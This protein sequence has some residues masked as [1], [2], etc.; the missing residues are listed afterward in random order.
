MRRTFEKAIARESR[1]GRVPAVVLDAAILYE[2]GWD[3]LCDLVVFVDAPPET[4]GSPG[5]RRPG[6]GPPRPSPPARRPRGR[7]TRSGARPTTSWPTTATPEE[8]RA[9]VEALWPAS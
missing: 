8:L 2:A 6:A 1:R 7:S 3:T 9:A 4:S 5:S